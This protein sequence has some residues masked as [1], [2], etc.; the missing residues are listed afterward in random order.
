DPQAARPKLQTIAAT[1][2]GRLLPLFAEHASAL[3]DGHADGLEATARRFEELEAL[4]LAAESSS[5]AAAAH[6]AAGKAA[7]A[8]SAEFRGRAL[9]KRS[10]A[11][12]TPWTMLAVDD[13]TAREREVAALAAAGLS[14]RAIAEQLVLS[15]RTVENHL[16]HVYRKL[17]ATSRI[18]L[19]AL[20]DPVTTE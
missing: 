17:G 10:E 3:A 6:R 1:A 13:L 8:R 11:S 18:D 15:G 14:N 5:E 4:L 20:P 12:H 9:L 2:Q 16:Q 19:P 7:S